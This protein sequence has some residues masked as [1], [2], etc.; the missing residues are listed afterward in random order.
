MLG[1]RVV[2]FSLI[3]AVYVVLE[4]LPQPNC[5]LTVICFEEGMRC[6]LGPPDIA[7]ALRYI[8][9]FLLVRRKE[10]KNLVAV[11]IDH[12]HRPSVMKYPVLPSTILIFVKIDRSCHKLI[13]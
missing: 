11:M 7:L 4:F 13:V 1:C 8:S 10:R 5:F 2:Y 9:I 6:N 12:G 3:N